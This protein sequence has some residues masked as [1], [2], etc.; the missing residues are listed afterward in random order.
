MDYRRN[1]PSAP[2]DAP[3]VRSDRVV[4]NY[5]TQVFHKFDVRT[6]AQIRFKLPADTSEGRDLF[7]DFHHEIWAAS[8]QNRLEIMRELEGGRRNDLIRVFKYVTDW[9]QTMSS[10]AKKKR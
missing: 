6:V 4:A 1:L 9:Q 8:A 7:S 3:W 2:P 5:V 10:M